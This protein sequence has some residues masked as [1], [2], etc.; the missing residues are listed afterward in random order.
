M[1]P[2]KAHHYDVTDLWGERRFYKLPERVGGG[3]QELEFFLKNYKS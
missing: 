3:D 1:P 2:V